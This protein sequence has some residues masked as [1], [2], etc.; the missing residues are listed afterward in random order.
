[1]M[2]MDIPLAM[3][4]GQVLAESGKNMLKGDNPDQHYFMKSIILIYTLIFF[5]P[6]PF[7]YFLGWPAWE[8][9]FLWRWQDHIMD[10]PL[11]A[12][13]AY[14]IVFVTVVP[15]YLGFLIARSWIRKGKEKWVRYSYIALL[16]ITGLI[17]LLNYDITFN[18][19]STYEKFAAGDTYSF[20][21]FPFW[22]GWAIFAAYYWVSLI[23]FYLWIK[24]KDK[25]VVQTA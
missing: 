9:N 2:A 13:S 15:A 12:A 24:K 1:M 4:T 25:L 11:R 17:V 8:L 10:N 18:V 23:A 21:T 22:L 7:Y 16:L 14:A 19:A 3:F 6:T 5:T 20:W